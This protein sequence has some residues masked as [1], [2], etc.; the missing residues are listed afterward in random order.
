M[1]GERTYP[2]TPAWRRCWVSPAICGMLIL[3]ATLLAPPPVLADESSASQAV[4]A[5]V[6]SEVSWGSANGCTQNIQINDFGTLTPNANSPSLEP[7]DALP[8]QSASTD[9]RGNHV[10]VGCVTANTTLE[11]VTASGLHDMI[12]TGQTLPLSNVYIGLTDATGGELNGG[13]AGCVVQ[14][15][16]QTI[17][18]CPLAVGGTPQALV[19]Q[20]SAGTTELDW[21]YQLDLPANQPVGSYSGGEVI[22]TATVGDPQTGEAPSSSTA[23]ALSSES[24]QEGRTINTTNGTWTNTPTSYTYQWQECDASGANCAAI[25]GATDASFLPSEQYVGRRL[26]ATVRASNSKGSNS[27]SSLPSDAVLPA[28]PQNTT[29]PTVSGSPF[30]E[31]VPL[32]AN[33][34]TWTG[35][36]TSYAYQWQY[37]ETVENQCGDL[38]GATSSTY[39]PTAADVGRYIRVRVIAK[40]AG[41]ETGSTSHITAAISAPT[42]VNLSPPVLSMS[43]PIAGVSVSASTGSWG[44][45]PTSYTYQWDRCNSSAEDCVAISGAT[46]SS[47]TP[48]SGDVGQDLTAEVT[49]TNA[50]GSAKAAALASNAVLAPKPQNTALPTISGSPFEEGVPLSANNGTWTGNPT[51]YTYQWGYCNTIENQCGIIGGATGS[52][53]T[54]TAA[55]VGRYIRVVVS[56]KNGSGETSAT[57]HLTGKI[58]GPAPVNTVLPVLSMS[59][60][61]AGVSVSVSKGSWTNSPTGYT[62]QWDRCNSSAEDCAAI[63]GATS[64]SYTPSESDVGGDLIAEVTATNAIGSATALTLPSNAVLAPR[65]QNTVLPTVTGTLQEGVPLSANNGT[66]TGNPTS[67]TYQWEHC[68]LGENPCGPISGAT[69]TTYT[70]TSTYLGKFI[71]VVVTAHNGSGETSVTSRAVGR[72]VAGVPVNTTAPAQSTSPPIVGVSLSV[73][74][75]SWAN[76]PSSYAYQWE[77][78][79]AAAENCVP[80]SGA[81]SASYTPSAADVANRLVAVVTASNSAGASAPAASSPNVEV[82]QLPSN[83]SAPLLSSNSP[84]TGTVLSVTNGSWS[85]YPDT[86]TYTY[87][88]L[89][90][91][92]NGQNCQSIA[93]ATSASYT[94]TSAD[95]GDK[96]EAAVTATNTAG[97][98][99]AFSAQTNTVI[100]PAPVNTALPAISSNTPQ[101]GVEDTVSTGTWT[102]SPTSFAYQWKDCNSAGEA[103]SNISGATASHYTPAASD[104]GFTLRVFVTASNT[105]GSASATSTAT[106]EVTPHAP[107]NTAAPTLS[108]STPQQG[109]ADSTSTGTWNFSPT[110]FSY[111]WEDCN[112]A[113]EACSNIS[114]A[115]SASY[116]PV[117]TDVGHTLRAKV[118]AS[119]VAG[120]TAASS[121]ASQL[122]S[123]ASPLVYS[124]EFG[125]AGTGNGQFSHP[126]ALALDTK[127][128]LWVADEG[129]NRIEE[130]NAKGEFIRT[131]GTAGSGNGQLNGP[132][133][134]AVDAHENAWV[135]DHR[136]HRIEEFNEKGEFVR[137]F[138][139]SGTANG[140]FSGAGPEGVAI[141]GHGNVW[142]SD[143]YDGRLQEFNEKG[144][145]IKIVGTKGSAEGDL[146][147]PEGLAINASGNVYV[148]DWLNNRVEEFTE[149]GGYVR[150]FGSEGTANG[151]FKKPYAISTDS[152]GNVWVADTQNDRVQKFSAAGEY[153]SKFGSV[154]T[155]AGQL[156]FSFPIGVVADPAGD[157]W[158]TSPGANTVEK[159]IP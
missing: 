86:F 22:L 34:G 35:S 60:P 157:V 95:V 144:E 32:S 108:S 158:V 14:A 58:S 16:Q 5:A 147:E 2:H 112:S 66:W 104:I 132:D 115:T 146:G 27:A 9:S 44:N 77:R 136:N 128:N 111:Q 84:V 6:A 80:I 51:S 64:S 82:Q 29:P 61:I 39:T 19:D 52:T 17:G 91:N 105:G 57:S 79:N 75:G 31:G 23:P 109:I 127:G 138:G 123:E 71:R 48:V 97:A 113:G 154:G 45:S 83:T 38:A 125:S 102:N 10:W 139:S 69:G 141:D 59:T 119:N 155:G 107:V 25:P 135:V 110:S 87:E 124:T 94:P 63:S 26:I 3:T 62:Y 7:F 50:I 42:P 116:T 8:N 150:E 89:R 47:Y 67:F 96:L 36:P 120:S 76:S 74:N 73:S 11:S 149:G 151:Q 49:A 43:T 114:G 121:A 55:D 54:P 156:S 28:A 46:S 78:C 106:G 129:N 33:N 18:A 134:I 90:C 92:S 148:A 41:G 122:V 13:P 103:C 85:G 4:Q 56:A 72:I 126:G 30:E 152:N 53:Y 140:Q 37:C 98:A 130:F 68:D 88:W 101:Q 93:A 70:P 65:P 99:A 21:Q 133:G 100:T 40:N 12:S 131:F 153:L 142:V 81:T 20:A 145:F 24:A 117:S 159:W 15:H 143:T 1:L 137:A 118:T